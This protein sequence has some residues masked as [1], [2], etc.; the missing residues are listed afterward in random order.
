MRILNV[1]FFFGLFLW[2]QQSTLKA[3]TFKAISNSQGEV[4]FSLEDSLHVLIPNYDRFDTDPFYQGFLILGDGNFVIIDTLKNPSP[5]GNWSHQYPYRDYLTR[6]TGVMVP[7]ARKTDH[8][9]PDDL[10]II[11]T[12]KGSNLL[13]YIQ[14]LGATST[15]DPIQSTINTNGPPYTPM[16]PANST[17]N[18]AIGLSH[19]TPEGFYLGDSCVHAFPI[20]YTPSGSRMCQVYFFYNNAHEGIDYFKEI[21]LQTNPLIKTGTILPNYHDST[22]FNNNLTRMG[23]ISSIS[24]SSL[25]PTSTIDDYF[26]KVLVY[27]LGGAN[28]LRDS[29]VVSSGGS[30]GEL[31][32]FPLLKTSALT[33]DSSKEATFLAVLYDSVD[34]IYQKALDSLHTA[35][36]QLPDSINFDGTIL[37]FS[38]FDFLTAKKGEPD[39]PGG[40]VIEDISRADEQN[41]LVEFKLTFCN[42]IHATAGALGADIFLR[43]P[44]FFSTRPSQDTTSLLYDFQFI[45]CSVPRGDCTKRSLVP[46]SRSK[47]T[48]PKA[49]YGFDFSDTLKAG[50]CGSIQFTVLIDTAYIPFLI[51]SSVADYCVSFKPEIDIGSFCLPNRV[52]EDSTCTTITDTVL[53]S[54]NP[55]VYKRIAVGKTCISNPIWDGREKP[56]PPNP[57]PDANGGDC[58][59]GGPPWIILLLLGFVGFLLFPI[60][61]RRK[62]KKH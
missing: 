41:Y 9:P 55:K 35:G 21:T 5:Q 56:S 6:H 33:V 4:N 28:L 36:V 2:G 10:N 20:A 14:V 60:I 23:W 53:V 50:E 54:T 26:D 34:S 48:N 40:L 43:S 1:I 16:I 19:H 7:V 57:N 30:P 38:G 8:D 24:P 27:R 42:D 46:G 58:E 13:P 18:I 37:R 45:E 3:Q 39:D 44:S 59:S 32:L 52:L 51:D 15:S 25:F 12:I 11:P 31:R 62:R 17:K 49:V 61:R 29:L 47:I 22:Q